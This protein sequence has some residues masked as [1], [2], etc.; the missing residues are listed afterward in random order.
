[1]TKILNLIVLG[2]LGDTSILRVGKF[3]DMGLVSGTTYAYRVR[4][5]AAAGEGPWS[6]ETVRM[7]P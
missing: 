1:M 7:A 3:A 6:D 4:A 2:Q 5:L